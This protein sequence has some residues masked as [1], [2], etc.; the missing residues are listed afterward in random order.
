M[1]KLLY[2]FI[3]FFIQIIDASALDNDIEYYYDRRYLY[4]TEPC[5]CDLIYNPVCGIDLKSYDN[6]C[7]AKCNKIPIA[8]NGECIS[9][10]TC[11]ESYDPVCGINKKTY[12]NQCELDCAGISKSYDGKCE[13]L[14]DEKYS[15]I[16]GNDGVTYLNDCE[17]ECVG[18]EM[19]YD[20]FCTAF[21]D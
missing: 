4:N 20:G 5:S 11:G 6:S 19:A 8:Y 2:I 10:C 21:S 9:D 14:C 12:S 13:C 17:M 7:V 3:Y 18:V 15:P 1:F 16:C